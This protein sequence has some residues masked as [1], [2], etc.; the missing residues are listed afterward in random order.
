MNQ[1]HHLAML[2]SD[3]QLHSA[4]LSRA[5]IDLELTR[6]EAVEQ[7]LG[8]AETEAKLAPIRERFDGALLRHRKAIVTLHGGAAEMTFADTYRPAGFYTMGWDRSE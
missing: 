7:S 4:E 5:A 2:V 1:S 8:S 6:R 3:I